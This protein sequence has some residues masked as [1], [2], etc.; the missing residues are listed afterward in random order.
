MAEA[1]AANGCIWT[2]GCSYPGGGGAELVSR[3]AAA[4]GG[5]G[6]ER[7]RKYQI[8]QAA[9]SPDKPITLLQK[10]AAASNYVLPKDYNVDGW[11]LIA[12]LCDRFRVAYGVKFTDA[13]GVASYV[14]PYGLDARPDGPGHE[15]AFAGG[16]AL[17]V[18]TEPAAVVQLYKKTFEPKY[19]P[20]G[21]GYIRAG[22]RGQ[23]GPGYQGTAFARPLQEPTRQ[24][25]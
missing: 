1:F 8:K 20:E 4:A 23:E 5:R 15:R 21:R 12:F 13:T 16:Q 11:L 10:F 17:H 2:W 9:A 7:T 25:P 14:T 18:G 19:D 3:I 22:Y 6:L 24:R